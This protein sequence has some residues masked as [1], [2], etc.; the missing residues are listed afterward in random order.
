MKY[1]KLMPALLAVL[2]LLTVFSCK[3]KPSDEGNVPEAKYTKISIEPGAIY[4]YTVQPNSNPATRYDE[5][6]ATACVQGLLNRTSPCFYL[7]EKGNAA[8]AFWFDVITVDGGWAQGR[9]VIEV[10]SFKDVLRLGMNVA[11]G[12]VVWDPEVPAT[13]NV[14]TTLA[15]LEDAVVMSPEMADKYAADCGWKIIK[16]FR[17]QFTGKETGSA[18]NDAYRWAIREYM[19]KG[20]VNTHI[21]CL[22][23]DSFWAREKGDVGYIV[24]RDWSVYGKCFV[25]DLSPWGDEQPKDDP[26]QRMGLD[27]ETYKMLLSSLVKRTGGTYG[28][29]VAG[30]FCFNKYSNNGGYVSKHDPVPT[31]WENVYVISPYNCYQNTVAS[32]CYNQS[33]HSQAPQRAMKQGRPA[34]GPGPQKGKTYIAYLMADYDSATP[35]YDFFINREI[36]TDKNRGKMPLLWGLNPNLSETYPDLFQYLYNTRT[37]NDWF[38]ADASAAGYMNPNRVQAKYLDAFIAHNKKFYSQ[39]DMSIS[40]MVLDW[41]APTTAVKD[42]FAEF[43]PDGFATIVMDMHN[44]VGRVPAPH[45]WKGMPV[46]ELLNAA[47][48]P[49]DTDTRVS[50]LSSCIPKAVGDKPRYFF[51]R[52]VWT[53]P[54]E[55]IRFTEKLKAQRTD[56]DIE[57]LDAY[58]FFNYFKQTVGGE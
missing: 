57:V 23:E 41:N 44:G 43:S 9:N 7:A 3:V 5:A 48:P 22:Y 26:S 32:S 8:N 28:T 46:M 49:M 39:W 25:Y 20:L 2:S 53:T 31:E 15:G 42:A 12:V 50:I 13:I 33:F 51:F 10:G 4:K 35:L 18:K 36:W 52:I 16:D 55:V 34:P 45:V 1:D 58:N 30:F 54:T 37:G 19:D 21:M 14:A 56:L 6:M 29:E 17:G 38:A 47:N 24:T 11:K 40:P 27:L